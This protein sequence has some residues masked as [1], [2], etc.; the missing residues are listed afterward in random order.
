MLF[1]L[2]KDRKGRG[3]DGRDETMHAEDRRA[4]GDEGC[5]TGENAPKGR[6][7]RRA[8]TVTARAGRN[9]KMNRRKEKG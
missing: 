1:L 2:V 9:S 6:N 5:E 3:G 7:G 8:K 4:R